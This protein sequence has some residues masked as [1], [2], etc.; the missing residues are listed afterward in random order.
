MIDGKTELGGDVVVASDLT[1]DFF[2]S[3][4]DEAEE[5]RVSLKLHICE[6]ASGQ[7]LGATQRG[8]ASP[9]SP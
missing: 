2:I 7:P 9:A 8:P 6:N 4:V 5:S 1:V 3:S